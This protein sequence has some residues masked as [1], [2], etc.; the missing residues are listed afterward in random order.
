[1]E[2]GAVEEKLELIV[3]EQWRIRKGEVRT[4][5]F[6]LEQ[7]RRSENRELGTVERK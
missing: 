6:R 7:W 3:V 5:R 4:G 1:V 2:G